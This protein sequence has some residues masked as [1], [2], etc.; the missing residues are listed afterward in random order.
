MNGCVGRLSVAISRS[1]NVSLSE[2]SQSHILK[3]DP[4]NPLSSSFDQAGGGTRGAF[5]FESRDHYG[6]MAQNKLIDSSVVK[7][8]SSTVSLCHNLYAPRD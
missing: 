7:C 3:R 6:N 2:P 4:E 1:D 8:S 5:Y